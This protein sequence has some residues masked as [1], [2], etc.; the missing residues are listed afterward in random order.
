MPIHLLIVDDSRLMHRLVEVALR[1]YRL[2]LEL[3]F[4]EDGFEALQQLQRHPD[5]ALVLLD[6]NMPRMSGLELL[7]RLRAEPV[8]A[9]IPVVLQSTE[10]QADDVSRGLAAGA[11]TY[12][13]KPFSAEQLH[14]LL[15]RVLVPRVAA[16]TGGAP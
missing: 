10:D 14:A 9:D 11:T 4:A 7:E 6:V 3:H 1:A 13:T 12:L 2:P 5:T 15:D 8:F 16:G